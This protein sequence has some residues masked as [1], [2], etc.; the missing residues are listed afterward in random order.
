MN[1]APWLFDQCLFTMVPFVKDKELSGYDF[2]FAPFWIRIYNIP[3]EC[4]DRQVA[5]EVGGAVG[6]V[7]AI[8]GRDRNGC[9]IEY[10]RIRVKLDTSKPLRRVVYMVGKDGKEL[11][12]TIKY[13]R[14]PTFCYVCGCI[15]HNTRRCEL[16]AQEMSSSEFQFGNWLRVQLGRSSQG[17]GRWRNGVEILGGYFTSHGKHPN[18]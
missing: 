4:M 17:P 12:C 9:W 16:Y 18:K 8:D 7:L 3:F 2:N 11:M 14:L 6:E 10:M 13:E 1:L 5:I 15:G